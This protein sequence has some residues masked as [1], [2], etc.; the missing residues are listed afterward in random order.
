MLSH[1]ASAE[2]PTHA[3]TDPALVAKASV[4]YRHPANKVGFRVG[5]SN[6]AA[7]KQ[8]AAPYDLNGVSRCSAVNPSLVNSAS[9]FFPMF[10][11]CE[12]AGWPDDFATVVA[13]KELWRLACRAQAEI[14]SLP[15]NGLLG[16][17]MAAVLGPRLTASVNLKLEREVRPLDYQAFSRFQHGARFTFR[18]LNQCAPTWPTA[19]ARADGWLPCR[20]CWRGSR[21][22]KRPAKPTR[23]A[24]VTQ[25]PIYPPNCRRGP[26]RSSARGCRMKLL[27]LGA[28][29]PTGRHV[30]DLALRSGDSVTAFVRNPAALGDL[31][32][33]VTSIVG[34][35]TSQRDV[36]AAAVG[37]DPIISALGQGRSLRT[38]GFATRAAE[39][40][41]GAAEEAH[42]SRLVW[43]S[44]FGVGH[45]LAWPSVPQKQIYR[46]ALRSLYADKEIG[47]RHA[48]PS[49]SNPPPIRVANTIAG[50]PSLQTN[51]THRLTIP[52]PPSQNTCST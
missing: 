32:G 49:L 7:A 45:I 48:A 21:H 37:Q 18:T 11:A 23:R 15:Q 10:S 26:P 46:T 13:D 1:Q 6:K 17:V 3:P 2:L 43:L 25:T 5:A 12:I 22:M 33:Q 19:S 4:C 41:V 16:K 50:R 31:A 20:N 44:A 51:G 35:A 52:T 27:I 47:G 38:N 14:M 36:A 39:T 24:R 28:T 40:V 42:V 29:G 30:V 8:F 34:D 9:A